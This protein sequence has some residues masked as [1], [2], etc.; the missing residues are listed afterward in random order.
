MN[1]IT[2]ERMGDMF[3]C[4]ADVFESARDELC[5]MDANMG[6]GDLGLTMAKGF[7]VFSDNI[8]INMA[9]C[10]GD[11]GKLL[12]KSAMKMSSAVPSTM[13]TL[14]S[15]GIMGAAKE[16]GAGVSKMEGEDFVKF[17]CGF[18]NGLEKRGKAQR[19]DRTVLDTFITAYE[20]A[21][22]ALAGGGSFSGIVE[23]ALKGAL[24]GVEAT[25][26]MLPKFGKAAVFSAKARGVADQGAVA[27]MY[28]IKGIHQFVYS[29]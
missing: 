17:L 15:S 22:E 23:E 7:R 18:K 13:G 16:I 2:Y 4:V 12:L 1:N 26:E 25:K 21:N 8:K 14:M 20:Y 10:S 28:F 29:E 9:E 6:D 3:E 5:E 27:G 24:A 11:I 19:G